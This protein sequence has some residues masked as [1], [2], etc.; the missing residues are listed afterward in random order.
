MSPCEMLDGMRDL[1]QGLSLSPRA[2][3]EEAPPL[4]E[5]AA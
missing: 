3:P 5:A 4:A 1:I 2:R